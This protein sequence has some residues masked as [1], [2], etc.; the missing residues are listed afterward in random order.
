V[1]A[2]DLFL[3]GRTLMGL[4]ERA[5]PH[6]VI[7]TSVR[8]VLVDV[9]Y[10]P[11]S[12]ISEITERTG[13]PQS[14]VS[15]SV[16]R[17]REIGVVDTTDDPADRRRTLVYPT[18]ALGQRHARVGSATPLEAMLAPVL[19]DAGP[20]QLEEA[21]AAIELLAGLLTP[22]VLQGPPRPRGVVRVPADD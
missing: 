21:V 13:F 3:L 11:G 12:S 18:P 1:N 14:H 20:D 4:A 9:A 10:H 15:Q 5:L 7:N 8:L 19:D 16:A 6:G 17:L 2:T 22:E